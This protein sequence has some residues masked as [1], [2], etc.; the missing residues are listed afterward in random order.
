MPFNSSVEWPEDWA[1]RDVLTRIKLATL[2]QPI[3]VAGRFGDFSLEEELNFYAA[4]IEL[5]QEVIY[6]GTDSFSVTLG[7]KGTANGYNA[8]DSL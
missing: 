4:H 8:S 2:N 7:G 1:G 5:D 6:S 3:V